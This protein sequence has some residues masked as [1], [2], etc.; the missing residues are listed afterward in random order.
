M[1]VNYINMEKNTEPATSI[2]PV[3][4]KGLLVS[5]HGE[6]KYSAT[7]LSQVEMQVIVYAHGVCFVIKETSGED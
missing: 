3:I 1:T 2:F 7:Y 6:T 5:D 4:L